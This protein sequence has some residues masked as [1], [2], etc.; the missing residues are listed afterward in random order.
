MTAT[1]IPFPRLHRDELA[2]IE[3]AMRARSAAALAADASRRELLAKARQ[4]IARLSRREG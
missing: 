3:A 2:R 4:A 1:V